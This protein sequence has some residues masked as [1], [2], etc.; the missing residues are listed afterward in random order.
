MIQSIRQWDVPV[1]NLISIPGSIGLVLIFQNIVI[2]VMNDVCEDA[3][4]NSRIAAHRCR[5]KLIAEYETSEKLFSSKRGNNPR[6]IYY[7]PNPGIVYT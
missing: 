6:Y 7:V 3:K 1:V 2:A 4:K 5:A